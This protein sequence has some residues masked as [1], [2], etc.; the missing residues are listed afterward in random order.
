MSLYQY[1]AKVLRVVDADTLWLDVSLGLD[2]YHRLTVRL[3][4]LNAPE[5]RTP[6]G[7]AATAFTEGW[8]TEHALPDGWLY[9]RTIKD[10]REKYGR[11]LAVIYPGAVDPIYG[12][13][14]NAALIASGHAVARTG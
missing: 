12:A 10:K 11:Y 7:V 13:S 6:E 9:L 2:T 1:Q 4:G 8:V 14:L 3:A 5:K